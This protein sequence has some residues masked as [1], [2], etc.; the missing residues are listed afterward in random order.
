VHLHIYIQVKSLGQRSNPCEYYVGT[1][2]HSI[3]LK[4]LHYGTVRIGSI[5]T[6]AAVTLATEASR[7][8]RDMC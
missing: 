1:E 8:E 4:D 2:G 3:L 5:L 7:A 6:M